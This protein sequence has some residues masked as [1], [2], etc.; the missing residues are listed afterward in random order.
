MT[1]HLHS[2]NGVSVVV[3]TLNRE[4]VL[5]DTLRDLLNQDCDDYEILVIDQSPAVNQD[6]LALARD[7]ATR[8]RYFHAAFRGL[9]QARNF[10]WRQARKEIV[11]YM[12][13]DIRA[14]PGLVR[15]HHDCYRN[16]SVH[17]V[18]GGIDE[19]AGD[20]IKGPTGKF[21]YWTATPHRNFSAHKASWVEHF[22]GCN[23]SCRR[24]ALAAVDGV[25]EVLNVG[26]ALYEE[27]DLAL[28]M[29]AKGFRIWFEPT[30]RLTHLAAPSGGCR[31][32]RDW[33]RYMYGLA[34]NRS[35]IIHRHLRPWHR[36]TA[37]ARL[38]LLGLSYSR[39]DRSLRPFGATLRGI[40]DGGK[41]A[42]QGPL[43]SPLEARECTTC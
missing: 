27:T 32:Q 6:V 4:A 11:L 16:P 13:D 10:G 34:H 38:L 39:L 9:P 2:P 8:I 5:L 23:F 36:P 28:R 26:A 31:V 42:M 37:L 25:D 7:H 21:Q 12:D 17:A 33:P 20:T 30:A 14:G 29:Q 40:R 15:A 43:S 22:K 18:A 41:A 19:A 35:I 24:S 1:D 3:P